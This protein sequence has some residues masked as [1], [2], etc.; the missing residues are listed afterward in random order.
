ML[1]ASTKVLQ[2]NLNR[3]S[4][5]TESA[6]QIA[7]ELEIDLILI[8]EP[9]I[10][11]ESDRFR[12]VLHSGFTQILPFSASP[13]IRPRTLAYI[14]KAYTPSVSLASDSLLDS[15]FLVLDIS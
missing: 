9:W 2:V 10:I 5:A 7:V 11:R 12:S 14:S 6:L 3:N 4:A 13:D 1:Y 15:G 8:Q